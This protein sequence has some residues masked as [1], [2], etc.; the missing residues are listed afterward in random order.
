VVPSYIQP[1]SNAV[2]ARST[3]VSGLQCVVKA[4]IFHYPNFKLDSHAS[5]H[6]S[7]LI[8]KM[9]KDGLITR[10]PCREKQWAGAVIVRHLSLS[11]I[12]HALQYG[13]A[14]WDCVLAKV[15]SIVTTA[16][17]GSRAGDTT[18]HRLDSHELPFLAYQDVVVTLSS[19]SRSIEDLV[20]V[21]TLRNEKMDK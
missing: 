6:L 21:Y 12:N 7:S 3:V 1:V 10:N 20:A 19:G 8:A 5:S 16:A 4:A 17:L 9:T 11:T 14:N 2:P 13:T 18:K 15:L